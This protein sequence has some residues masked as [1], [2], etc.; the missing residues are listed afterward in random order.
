M[1]KR[2]FAR[3]CNLVGYLTNLG[4]NISSAKSNDN[5]VNSSGLLNLA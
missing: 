5:V 2:Y 1:D 4:N 3:K